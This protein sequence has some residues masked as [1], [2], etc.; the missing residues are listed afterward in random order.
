[1]N[2]GE[3]RE[4]KGTLCRRETKW[5]RSGN[6]SKCEE[7]REIVQEQRKGADQHALFFFLLRPKS[8]A[9]PGKF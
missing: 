2:A 6:E 1:M 8:G 4:Q 9:F 5:N 3:R 7:I